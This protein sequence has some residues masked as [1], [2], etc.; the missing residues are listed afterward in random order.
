MCIRDRYGPVVDVSIPLRCNGTATDADNSNAWFVAPISADALGG[1]DDVS[2]NYAP[3]WGAPL[4]D[5]DW[6]YCG[7]A[8]VDP[9]D[10]F[11]PCVFEIDQPPATVDLDLGVGDQV[12][13]MDDYASY[14]NGDFTLQDYTLIVTI[15]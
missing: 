1:A 11:G 13:T 14:T 15:N 9:G 4:K 2:V 7:D 5:I 12:F 8:G 10:P 6:L 3:T